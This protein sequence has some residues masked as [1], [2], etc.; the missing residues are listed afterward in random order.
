MSD[1]PDVNAFDIILLKC[2]LPAIKE[3]HQKV[4][5]LLEDKPEF[6]NIEF[7]EFENNVL[8]PILENKLSEIPHYPLQIAE[9]R[10]FGALALYHTALLN[11]MKE[12]AEIISIS[13][14][15]HHTGS[16]IKL[17]E[18]MEFSKIEIPFKEMVIK[19]EI[20]SGL[21]GKTNS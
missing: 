15:V 21:S 8:L 18:E 1:T 5:K 9:I 12:S 19:V 11:A 20:A 7:D 17:V 2:L 3:V 10:L 16:L 13:N 6:N 14:L 4:T